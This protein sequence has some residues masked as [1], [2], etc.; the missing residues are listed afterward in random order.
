MQQV[1]AQAMEL[2]PCPPLPFGHARPSALQIMPMPEDHPMFEGV[3]EGHRFWMCFCF[4]LDRILG[5]EPGRLIQ[6]FL[7]D[8]DSMLQ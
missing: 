8:D 3:L 7:A 6:E 2:E 5:T 4:E 1:W